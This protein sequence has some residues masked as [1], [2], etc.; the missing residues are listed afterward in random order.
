MLR[1]NDAQPHQ[2]VFIHPDQA[3]PGDLLLQETLAVQMII[4]P[5]VT[6]QPFLYIN[7]GPDIE[8]ALHKRGFKTFKQY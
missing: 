2:G 4:I 6:A 8:E 5:T 3:S 1:V 7:N